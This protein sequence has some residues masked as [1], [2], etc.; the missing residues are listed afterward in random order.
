MQIYTKSP[1]HLKGQKTQTQIVFEEFKIMFAHSKN[2]TRI[3][4]KKRS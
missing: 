4:I 3:S 1:I 2:K